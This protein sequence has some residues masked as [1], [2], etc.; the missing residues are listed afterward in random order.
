MSDTKYQ[1]M[2]DLQSELDPMQPV[3]QSPPSCRYDDHHKKPVYLLIRRRPMNNHAIFCRFDIRTNFFNS[4]VTAAIRSVSL[5]RNS[6]ASLIIVVP[7]ACVASKA[8]TG[9]SS[10]NLGM[11]SPL[12]SVACN[13][14]YETLTVPYGS[15]SPS[16]SF[17]YFNTCT[18]FLQD[19]QYSSPCWIKPDILECHRTALN[20]CCRSHEKC[21]RRNISRY[22]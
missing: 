16:D 2:K 19:I 8:M 21:R 4:V 1:C 11:R 15:P 14:S 13:P 10:I 3:L 6:A 18:H 22:T 9:N 17:K 7:S 5:T 12:I 20:H